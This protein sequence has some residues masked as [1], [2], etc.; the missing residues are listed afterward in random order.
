MVMGVGGDNGVAIWIGG[1]RPPLAGH[2]SRLSR[3]DGERDRSRTPAL[4]S[5]LRSDSPATRRLATPPPPAPLSDRRPDRASPANPDAYNLRDTG[6]VIVTDG[7]WRVSW[8]SG[9]SAKAS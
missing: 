2:V 8:A 7:P 1:S 5:T 4:V 9:R 6:H 3:G